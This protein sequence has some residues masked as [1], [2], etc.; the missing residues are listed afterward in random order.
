MINKENIK[1][2]REKTGLG[3]LE[4]QNVLK[5]AGGN[6]KKALGL[7]KKNLKKTALK[8]SDRETKEGVVVS[9]IH[10]NRKVGVLLELLCETDFVAK[11]EE[12]VDLANNLAVHVAAMD[13]E[14]LNIEDA[15]KKLSKKE[16]EEKTLLCQNYFKNQNKKIKDLI[17]EKVQV[18]GEN[19]R[20]GRFVRYQL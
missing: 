5:E 15:P 12:F 1:K 2:L 4:C 18:L 6:F 9:Y 19:I 14:F 20:V 7:A 17:A 10:P 13:P 3:F 16:K 11:N 8:K